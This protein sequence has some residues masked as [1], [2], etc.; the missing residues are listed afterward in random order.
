MTPNNAPSSPPH[1]SQRS[2]LGDLTDDEKE[3]I[4]RRA[5]LRAGAKLSVYIHTVV[6]VLVMLLLTAI[7]LMTSPQ[8]LWLQWPLMGWGLG[9]VLHWVIGMRLADT[10]R[11][12]EDREIER[13]L[14]H[15]S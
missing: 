1:P 2:L 7:N 8:T 14:E 3:E 4:Y 15:V 11:A 10:Y 12:I 9:L 5:R 6:F 13:A